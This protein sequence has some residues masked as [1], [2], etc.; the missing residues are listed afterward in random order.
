MYSTPPPPRSARRSLA[1]ARRR[2]GG[3]R[4]LRIVAPLRRILSCD[5]RRTEIL[6]SDGVQLSVRDSGGRGRPVL[7]VHG[8]GLTQRSWARVAGR[9]SNRFRVV[10]YHQRGPGGSARAPDYSPRAFLRDPETV[11]AGLHLQDA[12]LGGI[13]WVG[14]W[15]WSRR[16]PIQTVPEWLRWKGAYRSISR[17]RLGQR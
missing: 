5:V 17:G 9:L 16:P 14:I 15:T 4:P 10:T 3:V 7:L 11:V 1:R 6:R 8:L 13:P 12:V 2:L